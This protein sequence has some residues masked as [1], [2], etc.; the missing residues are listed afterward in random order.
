MKTALDSGANGYSG[1]SLNYFPWLCAWVVNNRK[2]PRAEKVH[3]FLLITNSLQG[4]KVS[5]HLFFFTV[6]LIYIDTAPFSN[7]LSTQLLVK[8]I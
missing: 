2:D 8:C 5:S 3:K 1:I 4:Y 6:L 7:T